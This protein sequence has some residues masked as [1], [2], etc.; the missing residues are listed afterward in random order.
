MLLTDEQANACIN[1]LRQ[2]DGASQQWAPE[3]KFST[4]DILTAEQIIPYLK[5]G[6]EVF[7]CPSGGTYTFGSLTN[8]PTCS[9][10]GH[11]IVHAASTE[12]SALNNTG[13][14]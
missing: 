4:R 3:N 5:L 10:P 6:K 12:S 1:N 8:S 14:P 9:I 7:R 11:A 2:I 13:Q